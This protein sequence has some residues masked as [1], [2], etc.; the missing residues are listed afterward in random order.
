MNYVNELQ[1]DV[2]QSF[3]NLMNNEIEK[4]RELKRKEWSRV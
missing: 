1:L 3:E 2:C 4:D